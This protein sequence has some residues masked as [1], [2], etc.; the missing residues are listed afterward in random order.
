MRATIDWSYRLL[1]TEEQQMFLWLAVFANGFELDAAHHIAAGVGIDEHAATEHVASLV[2]KSMMSPESH[3]TGVRYRMLETVRAFALEQLEQRGERRAALTAQAEWVTTITDLPWNDACNATVER[4]AI[5]LERESDSWRDAVML[6]AAL[7][8]GD[9]AARLCGPPVAFFLLGRHDLADLVDP[10]LEPCGDDPRRRRAVLCALTVSA[11]G[12][13]DPN[14]LQAW[15]DEMQQIEEL[16]TTGLGGLMQWIALAWRGDFTTSVE[17][18]VASSLDPRIHPATRDLFVGIATLDHFSLTDATDDPHG[19]IDR[20][21]AIAD[22]SAVALHRVTCLLGAAWGLAGDDPVRSLQLVRRALN[23]MPDVPALTRHTLPG[24]ASRLLIRLD[25]RVAAQGLLELLASS[26]P[27]RSFVDLIPLFY[28]TTLLHR[29][30]HPSAES[31]LSALTPSPLTPYPSMMD[32]VDLAR[33][34]SSSN[35]SLSL[36]EL[37]TVAR[38]ALTDI[39]DGPDDTPPTELVGR[40]DRDERCVAGG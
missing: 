31:A 22:T 8:S 21:L 37:E 14:D 12:A 13:T 10:L 29:L 7:R 33:R 39:I 27:R 19:L 11:S 2:Q 34:A 3:P 17:M 30:G 24:S 5:R 16:E 9:L 25:P 18:C 40:D 38:A 1:G 20:A 36:S 15:V 35:N 32:I 28:S 4:S 6:A 23:D 26:S